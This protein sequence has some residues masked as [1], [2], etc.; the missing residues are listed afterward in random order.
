MLKNTESVY[1]PALD[2]G[3]RLRRR[4]TAAR[5]VAPLRRGTNEFLLS[6]SFDDVPD[7]AATLGAAVLAA[8]G[9]SASWY[10]ASGLLRKDSPSGR[11]L[12]AARIRELAAGGHEIAL[13][14]HS[15]ANLALQSTTDAV[16]DIRRNINELSDI[17]GRSPSKHFAYPYGE[18]S[19]ALKRALRGEVASA[20][21]IRA[22]SNGEGQD[23]LQLGAYELSPDP[24]TCSR[25]EA[26]M[27]Q[28]A[29]H[30]GWVVLF[31]HDVAHEPSPYGVTPQ[32]LAQ[33]LER[34]RSL[35]ARIMPVGEAF[36]TLAGQPAV[37]SFA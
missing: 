33:L 20:R 28:A 9:V 22:Q 19:V 13:H 31:T 3:A 7:S 36:L 24:A 35:G 32:V 26:A 27:A 10:V 34:A 4:W 6:V 23:R 17:L 12:D 2:F 5:T 18:T 16:F 21:G 37:V 25:A 30:G 14:G 11:I 1:V 29:R 8:Q 15:H